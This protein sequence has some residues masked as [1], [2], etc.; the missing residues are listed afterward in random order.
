MYNIAPR[1]QARSNVDFME[2][3][4]AGEDPRWENQ[5]LAGT[6]AEE[7]VAGVG[8]GPAEPEVAGA[9][10]AEPDAAG[11]GPADESGAALVADAGIV[12][13]GL[14]FMT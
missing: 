5:G 13:P 3:E 7:D 10:P 9:G 1:F 4:C 11:T 2:G 14:N 8:A 12:E 6:P